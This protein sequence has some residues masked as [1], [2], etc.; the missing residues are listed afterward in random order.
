[1]AVQRKMAC[2]RQNEPIRSLSLKGDDDSL[3]NE[4]ERADQAICR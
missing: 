2:H 3:N 1:M 4:K